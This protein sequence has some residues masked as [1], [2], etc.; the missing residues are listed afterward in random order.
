MKG[1]YYRKNIKILLRNKLTGIR[2][3]QKRGFCTKATFLLQNL[4]KNLKNIYCKPEYQSKT[5]QS[6]ACFTYK[7]EI[8][9]NS[10]DLHYKS[11]LFKLKVINM[12]Q[13]GGINLFILVVAF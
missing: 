11:P 4:L 2:S 6:A 10:P 12:L 5:Q 9:K 3:I 7:N 8:E 1:N 13:K